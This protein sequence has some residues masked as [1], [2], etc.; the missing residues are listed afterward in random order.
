MKIVSLMAFFS[1]STVIHSAP[2]QN[3]DF[4]SARTNSLTLSPLSTFDYEGPTADLLPGWQL[5][6][7]SEPIT[8]VGFNF[9]AD[10][11][12]ER[13]VSMISSEGP[14]SLLGNP[15]EGKY[16]PVFWPG[17]PF[18]LVQIG[19]IPLE[20][21]RLEFTYR[22]LPFAVSINGLNLSPAAQNIANSP[23]GLRATVDISQFAGQNVELKFTT[24]SGPFGPSGFH[25]IDSIRFVPPEPSGTKLRI[26]KTF[27]FDQPRQLTLQFPPVIG[28]DHFVEFRDSLDPNSSWQVLPGGPHNS[29]SVTDSATNS[30]RF[31]RVR[32]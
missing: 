14:N 31:Y 1:I 5:F 2:F 20:A 17:E 13:R 22:E 23:Y 16:S 27:S 10:P 6:F 29:G 12:L 8:S 3:L 25:E 24:S 19:E 21:Q 9:S 11:F 32:E 7:D 15:I 4:E 26:F 30:H 28:R 18:S